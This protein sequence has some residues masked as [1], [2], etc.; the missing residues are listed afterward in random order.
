MSK[1]RNLSRLILMDPNESNMEDI[2]IIEDNYCRLKKEA[3]RGRKT[4]DSDL[5]PTFS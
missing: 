3:F 4:I 2:Q 1:I 5:C